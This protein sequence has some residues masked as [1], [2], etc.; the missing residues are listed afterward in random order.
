[1]VMKLPE[2][3]DSRCEVSPNHAHHFRPLAEVKGVWR[4]KYCWVSQ[5]FP[6]AWDDCDK[7]SY[8]IKAFGIDEAYQRQ[9]QRRPGVVRIL[10][11]LEEIRLLRKVLPKKQ[12]MMAIAAIVKEGGER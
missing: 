11:K 10:N 1:M 6:S 5:W 3:P 9:L 12:L 8:A 2:Y 4:C 7:F